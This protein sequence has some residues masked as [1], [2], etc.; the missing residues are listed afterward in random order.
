METILEVLR[1]S[2][3]IEE[4]KAKC[5]TLWRITLWEEKVS[6]RKVVRDKGRD[7]K[8]NGKKRLLRWE[9]CSGI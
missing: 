8:S 3:V 2:F 4:P 9:L 7:Q 6:R 5:S 1:V